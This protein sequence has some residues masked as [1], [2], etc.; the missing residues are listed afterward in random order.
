MATIDKRLLKSYARLDGSGR[1]VNSSIVQRQKKPRVGK[2]IEVTTYQCC[3]PTTTTTTTS[4]V[5]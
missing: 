2:W 1:V 5:G 4:R 3:N